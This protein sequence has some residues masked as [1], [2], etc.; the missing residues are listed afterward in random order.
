MSNNRKQRIE[1]IDQRINVLK[2]RQQL[3]E[4]KQTLIN[5]IIEQGIYDKITKQ[6]VEEELKI[7]GK[8]L[9]EIQEEAEEISKELLDLQ[10]EVITN[11]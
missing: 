7:I 3:V 2:Y 9:L 4:T 5:Y 1:N 10:R 8:E 11:S 6:E